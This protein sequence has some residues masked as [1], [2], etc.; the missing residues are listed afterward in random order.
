M[1]NIAD[2]R[3]GTG[4]GQAGMGT[5]GTGAL[6]PAARTRYCRKEAAAIEALI[7]AHIA[8]NRAIHER[9][10]V[11]LNPATNVMN[12]RAEA[13]LASGLGSRPSLG[14]PGDKYEM[15]LEAIEKIEVIAAE[16][17]A[18]GLRRALCRNQG[19][20]GRASPISMPSWRRPSPATAS[21]RRRPRSAAMSRITRRA[22]PASTGWRSTPRRSTRKATRSTSRRCAS[23]RVR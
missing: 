1:E 20:V 9:D 10:C 7:D 21:S 14:Y 17:A 13:A 5:G 16:L 18:R 12:P 22:A 8:E 4:A 19:S 11:N 3:E 15:G 6:R 23:R 2:E